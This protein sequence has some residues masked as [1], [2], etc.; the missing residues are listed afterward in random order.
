MVSIKDMSL[1]KKLLGGFG[2]VCLLLILDLFGS[3]VK[4]GKMES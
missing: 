4:W 2:L 3:G 1:S